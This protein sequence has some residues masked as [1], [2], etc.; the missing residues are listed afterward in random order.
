M[1]RGFARKIDSEKQNRRAK[2]TLQEWVSFFK[3]LEDPRGKQG[4]EHDFLSIVMI[5]ILAVIA[6]AEGWDD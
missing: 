3:T 5:T 2:Q 6:G 1:A 4:R